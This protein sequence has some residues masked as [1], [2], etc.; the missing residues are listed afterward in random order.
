MNQSSVIN[1][2]PALAHR[3]RLL[4]SEIGDKD[5]E[6]RS[7]L[8]RE[9][10]EAAVK[11]I[12][13]NRKAAFLSELARH[14]P[15]LD[16]AHAPVSVPPGQGDVEK[17]PSEVFT[18]LPAEKQAEIV[19]D[20]IE[21]GVLDV[22]TDSP[23]TD[24][25]TAPAAARADRMFCDLA[26][27]I[28]PFFLRTVNSLGIAVEGLV[29]SD[30]VEKLEAYVAGEETDISPAEL[31]AALEQLA[32]A[33]SSLISVIPH[34]GRY[35]TQT[36]AQQLAAERIEDLARNEGKPAL[37][38]WDTVY[39]GKYKEVS[40]A[41]SDGTLEKDVNQKVAAHIDKWLQRARQHLRNKG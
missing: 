5:P 35:A 40:R 26:R 18:S 36:L 13:D 22:A 11:R 25:E 3:L 15:V 32:V 33:V 1:E 27:G 17:S 12:P 28:V 7:D 24:L 29:D 41:F 34:L 6:L 38:R 2:A 19:S 16:E 9:Q 31:D 14:F 21:R 39:W 23:A 4:Q 30:I 8:L 20:L 37:Q 10:I